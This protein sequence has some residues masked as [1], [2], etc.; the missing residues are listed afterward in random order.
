MLATNIP[1]FE[2]EIR[3]YMLN[4][5][6]HLLAKPDCQTDVTSDYELRTNDQTS[7]KIFLNGLSKRFHGKGDAGSLSLAS[8]RALIIA[9]Q[10]AQNTHADARLA[11]VS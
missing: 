1:K 9:T 7:Y 5:V 4:D 2:S 8:F 10:V 6:R 3:S 11:H